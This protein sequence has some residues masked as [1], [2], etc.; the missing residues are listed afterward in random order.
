M[1]LKAPFPYF[2]GKRLAAPIIWERFGDPGGYVEPFCG[3]AAVLLRR[4]SFRG[5]RVETSNDADGWI[6]NVWRAIK[7]DPAA[8]AAECAGPLSEVDINAR[9][10][11]LAERREG[12]VA[13][14][15]GDPEHHDVKAAAWWLTA[16]SGAI[17]HPGKRGPW[18]RRDGLLVFDPAGNGI[19]RQ[20]PSLS[21]G[22][23]VYANGRNV[24]ADLMDLADRLSHVRITCGDWSRVLTPAAMMDRNGG[25]GSIAVLLDPPYEVGHDIY[26]SDGAGLSAAARSWCRGAPPDM[27]IALCGYDDEHDELLAH[28]WSKAVGKAGGSGYGSGSASDRE[29]VWFSPACLQPATQDALFGG[30]AA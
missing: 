21:S 19:S 1:T 25:D 22:R 18:V 12:F 20:L 5:R 24:A 23:G 7:A 10:A 3:S 27:R 2:G 14:L 15:E 8:V 28:G 29:R 26:A 17:G 11:W 9:K 6:A 16:A 30:E 13:W 4:P